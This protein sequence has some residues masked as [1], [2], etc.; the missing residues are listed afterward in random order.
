MKRICPKGHKYNK[1]SDY[2]VCPICAKEDR[3]RQGLLAELSHPA[4]R[5]LLAEGIDRL[6][7]L[8]DWKQQDILE[9]HGVGPKAIKVL[10]Q[11]LEAAGL[12]FKSA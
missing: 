9:L 4:Q 8:A 6:D 3:V 5:V 2:P 1:T 11:Q 7:I 10:Q 12:S